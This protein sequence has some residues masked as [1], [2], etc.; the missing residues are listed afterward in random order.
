[1]YIELLKKIKALLISYI[2][3]GVTDDLPIKYVTRIRFINSVGII[4]LSVISTFS[5]IN[6]FIGDYPFFLFELFLAIV[7]IA[8]I[9]YL[10]ETSDI[11]LV[12][13]IAI[14][15]IWAM[16]INNLMFGG[17]SNTGVY[18]TFP[19]PVVT[20]LL[21]DLKLGIKWILFFFFTY[22]LSI[23]FLYIV[24]L[25]L[26]YTFLE[27]I[28]SLLGLIIISLLSHFFQYN[29][30]V[31]EKIIEEQN[32]YLSEDLAE[33]TKAATEYSKQYI[34][35]EKTK[36]AMLNLVEDLESEQKATKRQS[37]ELEK[38]KEAV[39]NVS[40]LIII[41]DNN[42]KILYA[43]PSVEKI[44]GFTPEEVVG[45]NPTLWSKTK[46]EKYYLNLWQ[47][48]STNKSSIS[49][50]TRNVRKGGKEYYA[51]IS[52]SPIFDDN[53]EVKSFV[54]I[55]KDISQKKEMERVKSEF[56]SVASHQLR[57]PLTAAK[58]NLEM[59][60]SNQLGELTEDQL[61]T[62]NQ[63]YNTNEKMIHLV[64]SYLDVSK[65]DQSINI[66]VTKLKQ[67]LVDSVNKVIK[68]NKVIAED[69]QVYIN[70]NEQIPEE[71]E[72][73]YA[74]EQIEQVINQ[75]LHNAIIYS[76]AEGGDININI[77]KDEEHVTITIQDFG[78]GVPDEDKEQIFKKFFR[79]SNAVSRDPDGIGLGLYIANSI[80]KVHG[81][82]MEFTSNVD[83]GTT[84]KIKL[85][86]E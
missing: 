29:K 67:N 62:V 34:S 24:N 85:P 52:L 43:N 3:G 72:V 44:T 5:L 31:T 13:N 73:A 82:Q 6:L 56:I 2:N 77:E 49:T 81:G 36:Y 46:I 20:F 7:I 33:K 65:F 17:F 19:I 4:G 69:K 57:T 55:E 64:N 27:V 12:S 83:E 10:R 38:F 45:S 61:S 60:N 22:P 51:Q 41:T 16:T 86:L 48:L 58:W 84:V 66:N 68:K 15:T 39:D 78:I 30:E 63:I 75:V 74:Q 23:F 18:L 21:T 37:K 47:I 50:E 25:P 59:L 70:L 28:V 40:D 80:I 1:M 11:W 9:L 54:A 71:V 53:G 26:P 76:K 32:F 8:N 42:S 79:A 35:L 14:A